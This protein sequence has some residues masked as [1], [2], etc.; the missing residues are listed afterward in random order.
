MS[1]QITN[2]V[3]LS[4]SNSFLAIILQLS[5]PKTRLNSNPLLPGSYPGVSKLDSSLLDYSVE[6]FFI[7][8]LHGPHGKHR[9][10]LSRIALCVFTAPLHCSSLDPDHIE[11]SLS[12]VEAYLPSRC[13]VMCMHVT[14]VSHLYMYISLFDHAIRVYRNR[15]I[16]TY[17]GPTFW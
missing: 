9:L 14:L 16:L 12:T 5:I 3:F 4:Q 7:N 15:I 2:E 13:L 10:L 1:R 11:N 17:K 8:I 6:F